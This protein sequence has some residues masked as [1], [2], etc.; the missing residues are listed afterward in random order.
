MLN[1]KRDTSNMDNFPIYVN[2][3]KMN[4]EK[5]NIE[6]RMNDEENVEVY[7]EEG[8][9]INPQAIPFQSIDVNNQNNSDSNI[10]VPPFPKPI[11][12]H[13]NGS[14]YSL[15]SNNQVSSPRNSFVSVIKPF[16]ESK[17][18]ESPRPHVRFKDVRNTSMES[19][20]LGPE[21]YDKKYDNYDEFRKNIKNPDE[22]GGFKVLNVRPG[23]EFQEMF[24]SPVQSF[25]PNMNKKRR[26]SFFKKMF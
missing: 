10:K 18:V 6:N 25:S 8:S 9:F 23:Y 14:N 5:G 22:H 13:S 11:M 19:P 1:N 16:N 21:E 7:S 3:K 26:E 12:N 15:N 4:G 2:I 20:I 17:K 24:N